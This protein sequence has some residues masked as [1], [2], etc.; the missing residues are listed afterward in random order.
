VGPTTVSRGD[1]RATLSGP[2]D[3]LQVL[4]AAERIVADLLPERWSL[5]TR[6]P[7]SAEVRPRWSV[8]APGG[9]VATYVVVPGATV[10]G[11]QRAAALGALPGG[12]EPLVVGAFLSA[13]VREELVARG[14]SHVDAT[15]NVWL[16]AERPGLHVQRLGAAKDPW[17]TDDTL[18]SL[19]G[20]AA[21]RSVRALVDHRPP[22]GVRELAARARVPLGSLSR[23]LDLLDREGLVTRGERGDVRDLDWERVVR[24]WAQD[25]ELTRSNRIGGYTHPDGPEAMDPRLRRRKRPYAVSGARGAERLLGTP[26]AGTAV[27]YVEDLDLAA[28]RLGLHPVDEDADVVLAEGYDTVVFDRPIVVDGICVAAPAQLV[29]D[30]LTTPTGHPDGADA[31]LTWMRSHEA[32]WR[33]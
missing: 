23:T 8:R 27:L 4:A 3:E 14:V 31:L 10:S 19:R 33:C 20:R 11:R 17:P 12:D 2:P 15:G 29:A 9:E 18:R 32:T 28:E 30:L 21:G 22:Y 13:T 25:Y 24:R 6:R 16:V 7:R 1:L 5:R 26:L